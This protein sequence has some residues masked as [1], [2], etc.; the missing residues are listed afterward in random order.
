MCEVMDAGGLGM[1]RLTG[2]LARRLVR[3]TLETVPCS[4]LKVFGH[5]LSRQ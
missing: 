4:D 1:E 2:G 3:G 5:Y